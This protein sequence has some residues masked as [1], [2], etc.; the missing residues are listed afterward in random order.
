MYRKTQ[1]WREIKIS[2]L[3]DYH[4]I[5]IYNRIKKS[6]E[7]WLLIR[8]WTYWNSFNDMFYDEE[9]LYWEDV[10]NYCEEY[11]QIRKE[12]NWRF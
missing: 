11:Q 6:A 2:E 5:N 3:D 8:Y 12:F 1:D 9:I 4:L 10:W 7:K